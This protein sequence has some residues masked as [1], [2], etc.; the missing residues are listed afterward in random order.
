MDASL[1]LSSILFFDIETVS[2]EASLDEVPEAL[3]DMWRDKAPRI[4]RVEELDEEEVFNAYMDK[5]AIFAEFGRI[6][7]ISVGMIVKRGD[8]MMLRVKSFADADERIVLEDFLKLLNGSNNIKFL[9]GHNIREFDVPYINRRLLVQRM[10]LPDIL[11]I[12][13]KKPWE[14]RHFFD[15]MELWTFGDRKNY[16]SLKLLTAVF[17]IPSPK[18][19]ID[20][21]QVGRVFWED[22]DLDRIALYCEKDVVATANVFL[23]M[24]NRPIIAP[25]DVSIAGRE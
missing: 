7:C 11:D 24:L 13:G 3:A 18:D 5:S 16:T 23:S 22:N 14:A 2:G 15:T 19:D 10:D 1:D 9:C 4:M 20:G 21:S 12:R 17:G 8:K 25:E 6:V